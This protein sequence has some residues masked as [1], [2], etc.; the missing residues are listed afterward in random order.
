MKWN[1]EQDNWPDF[2]YDTSL[3]KE[4]EGQFAI[5][6][7]K[8]LGAVSIIGEDERDRFTVDLLSEEALKS[9]SIEGEIL[10]RDS[11]IS[12]LLRQFGLEPNYKDLNVTDK[13]RGIAALVTDNYRS[14]SEP[15]T[16]D[17]LFD[18]HPCVVTRSLLVRDVGKYRTS[19]EKMEVVSGP[20]G[21][22]RVHFVAPPADRVQSEMETFI[23]W[24]NN[25]APDGKFPLPALTRAGTAHIYFESV[26]P[27]DD[28]NGRIGRA[29]SEKA[30]AQSTGRPALVSL[31]HVIDKTRKEYYNQLEKNNKGLDI[32]P[33]L[34][35]FAKTAVD[36]VSHS[37]KLVRYTVEKTKLYDRVRDSLNQR[38][39]KALQLMF[40]Q[41]MDGFKGGMTADKYMR[42]TGSIRK[43]A[44]RDLQSLVA[45]GILTKT[46][47]RKG[48]RYWLNLG[49]E[50]DGQKSTYL[51]EQAEKR[52]PVLDKQKKGSGRFL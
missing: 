44:T 20:E 15:L 37:Q 28:G 39:D 9:S 33:W 18:W 38:Q 13:E 43:T 27:F 22:K 50:F 8:L 52:P 42:T 6:S 35:Y 10:N 1:W 21:R 4:F 46:G 7:A 30:L 25:T 11:V 26:H 31:S 36:A 40:S 29:I 34:F 45:L 49:D 51:K 17:R 5:E 48:T 23:K 2:N 24:F 12:S 41:G 32:T 19:P 47:E 3:L 16:H 14:H